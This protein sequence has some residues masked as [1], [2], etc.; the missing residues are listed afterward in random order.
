MNSHLLHLIDRLSLPLDER[1]VRR[2]LRDFAEDTGFDFFAYLY[3]RGPE[4]FAVSSYPKEWQ[5]LYIEREYIRVDPVVTRAKHGPP[6][7][8]WSAVE[9]RRS[10]RRDVLK[11]YA[12]AERF[13]IRSGISISI[14]VG[15][16]ER[17][18]FTLATGRATSDRGDD[19]N[20][21]TA[22]V[23]V[24]F[25]HS[26]LGQSTGGTSLASGIRLSPREAECLRWFAEGTSMP[27]IALMLGIAYRSVRSYLDEATQK[28]GASNTRQAASIAIRLGLI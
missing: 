27:D 11:F 8:A 22:A 5:E 12:D 3:L 6:I 18:V 2:A 21:V 23:S 13:G 7:F 9:A 28:L 19:I 20:P 10:G 17:M 24:A 26:R 14:P 4:S 25:V 1:A 16:T 15:F